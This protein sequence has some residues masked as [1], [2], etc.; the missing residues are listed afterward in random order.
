MKFKTLLV[1]VLTGLWGAG[2]WWWYTCNIKGFCGTEQ[3]S[4]AQSDTAQY[5]AVAEAEAPEATSD[6]A[7]NSVTD[8]QTVTPATETTA[9]DTVEKI[10]ENT[11][12]SEDSGDKAD[13][14]DT[15][16]AETEADT[17]TE[18]EK[19]ADAD[20][21]IG[22]KTE[23][24][25]SD[26]EMTTAD[27]ASDTDSQ[28]QTEEVT[29]EASTDQPVA[30]KIADKQ[31]AA[32]EAGKSLADSDSDG[33]PDAVESRLGLDAN[34]PDSDN[35][36][37]NDFLETGDDFDNPLDT[38]GD[39][40]INALDAD[41]DGDGDLTRNEVPDPNQDG[42]PD[43][44]Q[45]IDKN[46]I[47]DYLDPSISKMSEDDDGD[48]ISN[49]AE[50]LLGTNP[51]LTDSDGDGLSDTFEA[52]DEKDSDGDGTIDALDPDDDDDGI[53]TA[54]ENADP[55]GDGN[56][57]DALDSNDNGLPDYLDTDNT[58]AELPSSTQAKSERPPKTTA[59]ATADKTDDKAD[60]AEPDS[61]Q[62]NNA[63]KQGDVNKVTLD[64]A[65]AK[66][67]GRINKARLYFPFRSAEPELASEVADYFD[68]I[69]QQL[70][71]NPDV[72]IRVTGHTDSIGS[73]ADNRKLGLK[74]AEQVRDMLV[75][76]GAP[77]AQILVHS[78]GEGKWLADNKTAEGR[79]KNRRVEIEQVK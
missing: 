5:A 1:L 24:E 79:K 42:D 37:V 60:T 13:T 30:D 76:R 29:D 27:T 53:M 34:N 7:K 63:S 73:G 54:M 58:P 40:I 28:Q 26:K 33:V 56:P 39:K 16:A 66:K 6:N 2:S 46:N 15:E 64:T 47:P 49:G 51:M 20:Q 48:G 25:Q 17:E 44:A 38:D 59:K 72:K 61:P 50:R 71:D 3:S 22:D 19:K 52:V 41:D 78:E 35:D 23:L 4:L 77:A 69:I 57:E 11:K 45:D 31:D 75:K 14:T 62:E 67:Q 55:N 8:D 68:L 32:P 70:K 65:G 21:T 9:Q 36:G 10:A 43:D 18:A 12:D 74:R